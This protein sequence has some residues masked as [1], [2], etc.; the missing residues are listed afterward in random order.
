MATRT[1]RCRREHRSGPE[2]R[3]TPRMNARLYR[4]GGDAG[5]LVADGRAAILADAMVGARRG[6]DDP[7][8]SRRL[9]D[10][11]YFPAFDG[12]RAIA[13]LAVLVFHTAFS[14]AFTFRTHFGR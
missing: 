9:A 12:Y 2:P 8:G 10:R 11:K 3:R 5:G 14:S 7:T 13:A 6:T 4:G 1:A